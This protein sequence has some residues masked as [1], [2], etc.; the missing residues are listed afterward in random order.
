[1]RSQFEN[2]NFILTNIQKAQFG[3]KD[4]QS[5]YRRNLLGSS[6]VKS[7]ALAEELLER[8]KEIL[9]EEIQKSIKE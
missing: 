7:M 1:M 2:L 3:I 4:I 5:T 9:S 8:I 6:R